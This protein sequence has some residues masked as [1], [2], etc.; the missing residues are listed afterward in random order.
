MSSNMT[1]KTDSRVFFTTLLATRRI[2]IVRLGL[3][4]PWDHSKDSRHRLIKHTDFPATEL[5][6]VEFL[7]VDKFNY[8]SVIGNLK[9]RTI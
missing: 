2:N 3:T 7:S 6:I 1:D 9:C 4:L 8:V 5:A